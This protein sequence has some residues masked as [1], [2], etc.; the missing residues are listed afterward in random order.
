MNQ[1]PSTKLIETLERLGLG[2]AAQ[3]RQVAAWVRRMAGSAP[4]SDSL[5][6]DA[7]VQSR[8]LTPYQAAEIRADRAEHLRIGP[9]ILEQPLEWPAYA[10][11]YVARDAHTGKLAR[12]AVA[13]R[14]FEQP[15]GLA[16]SGDGLI[17]ITAVGHELD[18]IWAA[19]DWIPAR[20]A[21]EWLV[22]NGRFPPEVVLGIARQ[23][24]ASLAALHKSGQSHGD[25]STESL[26]ITSEGR[27]LMVAPGLRARIRPHEPATVPEVPVRAFD[28][29][30][31]ERVAEGEP[32]S[33]QSDLFSCGCVWWHLLTGRPPLAGATRQAKLKAIQ[34][35][36]IA[37]VRRYAPDVPSELADIIA[38]CM[39]ARPE[40]RPQS[41]AAVVE[42]LGE[43]TQ[44]GQLDVAQ[45][46]TG[47]GRT[48]AT[49]LH[50]AAR[51]FPRRS[52]WPF[53]LATTAC[54]VIA[55]VMYLQPNS[56]QTAEKTIS[57]DAVANAVPLEPSRQE[58]KETVSQSVVPASFQTPTPEE[59]ILPADRITPAES[60][61]LR[62]GLRIRSAVGGRAAIRVP[63]AGMNV[64]ADL[65]SFEDVDFVWQ[66]GGCNDPALVRVSA[67]RI[68]FRGCA[69]DGP[70]TCSVT[71]AA[72]VWQVRS[73][74]GKEH[75]LSSGRIRF[76]NC[77]HRAVDVGV[78]CR[79]GGANVIEATNLLCLS[80]GRWIS[81]NRL[82]DSE[83]TL[84]VNLTK[85][86][87]RGSGPILDLFQDNRTRGFG[88]V[89]V[90]ANQCV[91]ALSSGVP[92]LRFC[93]GNQPEKA[94]ES[95]QWAGQGSLMS[96]DS[97]VAGW[98][99]SQTR[100]APLDENS[101][102]IAG[103]VRGG[104]DFA[105]PLDRSPGASRISRWA[106]PLLSEESPGAEM[107]PLPD[108]HA[109]RQ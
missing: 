108:F 74:A 35:G 4:A 30:A 49:W 59:Y 57:P 53:W 32:P 43:P 92:L 63:P 27:V 66:P 29:L 28:Y 91:F 23:M 101:L 64:D 22:R 78:D 17:P 106:V 48:F 11:G 1:N 16:I 20:T 109:V 69:F 58:P 81:L 31:P 90:R 94:L 103:L 95:I 34:S 97:P 65:V 25:I 5:W 86:T 37:D 80:V 62:A 71:P 72:V 52:K 24:A 102:S 3:V 70:D 2:S 75:A 44:A 104:V 88:S 47:D 76:L 8:A 51:S 85:V 56:Q 87:H 79:R 89:A 19:A 41:A 26:A 14:A 9:W 83:E 55:A 93:G 18:R 42:R 96:P 77:V 15:N 60:V 39:R 107:A 98:R 68:T 67:G 36:K 61:P 38:A 82:P 13:T 54:L 50:D 33:A 45:C 73:G 84:I 99:A 40:Q 6:V 21:R 7:L 100:T 12:L 46:L 10:Q 105:G